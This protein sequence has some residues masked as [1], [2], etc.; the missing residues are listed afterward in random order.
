MRWRITV[1][2]DA[3]RV[4]LRGYVDELGLV[5]ELATA[6]KPLDLIV[7][8]SPATAD[9]DPFSEGHEEREIT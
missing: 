3:P 4:E 6:L 5:Q 7:V 2:G 9:Y 8:A 1:R